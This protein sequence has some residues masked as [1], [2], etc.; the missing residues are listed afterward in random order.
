MKNLTSYFFPALLIILG[1]VLLIVG[2]MQGQN[3]WVMLG[4][5]LALMTGV[6][7][8]LLQMGTITRK[9]GMVLGVVFGLMAVGL[10]YRN[11]RSVK[12]V[13]EFTEMKK[14]NDSKIIQALKDIRT[15][16]IG[17]R[18]ANGVFTG[19]IEVLRGFVTSGQIPMVRS[20]GQVPDT[21]T[22]IEA[23]ELKLIV[24]DTLMA[25]ALDSLFR[26]AR[27]QEGRVY[28]FDPSTFGMSPVSKKPFLLKAGSISSSN[29]NVPVFIAKDP[30][31]LVEGDTLMV[32]N[33][34]KPSTAGNWSGE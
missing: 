31:P 16:Q 19:N 11:Y 5:G 30:T 22:E 9:T 25:P 12:E 28:P 32:G 23:L 13:L 3:S 1:G 7:S 6:I 17:Y 2:A 15:A 33:M 4:S 26:S 20:V 8:L 34:E 10:T 21:L 27:A 18:Q 29:R 24:R 14:V